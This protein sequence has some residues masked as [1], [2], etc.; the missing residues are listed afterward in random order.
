MRTSQTSSPLKE[1]RATSAYYERNAQKYFEL[2][3]G[4]DMSGLYDRFLRYIPR[5]GLIL[6][7]GSGSGR[8]TLVFLKRGYDVEAFDSSPTLCG[9]STRLTGVRARVLRFQELESMLRYDGV[10]ACA[11]LLHVPLEELHDALNRLVRA[12]KPSGA[13]YVSFKHGSGQRRS[14]DGRLYTDLDEPGLRR[15]FASFPNMTLAQVWISAG[16]GGLRGKHEWL[17]AIALKAR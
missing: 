4:I 7:A 16:E 14:D 8:D 12:L 13:L 1:E 9:L 2:T 17:N 5:R 3:I 6:D 11:S 15:L 10:W